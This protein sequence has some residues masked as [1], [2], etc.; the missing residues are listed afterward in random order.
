MTVR[1]INPRHVEGALTGRHVL[2]MFVGFFGVVF[3]VNGYMLYAALSTHAGIV[4]NEP[5]RK[6]LA[7]NE[8]IAAAERQ[9]GLGWTGAVDVGIDGRVALAM[10]RPDGTSLRGL[11]IEGNIGRP[12]TDRQDHAL[13]FVEADG[14]Y[15][16]AA[17]TLAEGA[18][19][20]T[21]EAHE[22]EGGAPVFRSRRRL[23]LKP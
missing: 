22:T 21:I 10:A 5:Y 12:S 9:A 18:W 20:L 19:L 6:G 14:R 13:K 2:A 23:W 7:Y 16:A 17:G 1:V 11:L 4:A 3:A 8:R 15:V